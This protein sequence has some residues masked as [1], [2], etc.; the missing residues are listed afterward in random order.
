MQSWQ[1]SGSDDDKDLDLV[2]TGKLL[3]KLSHYPKASF[4]T[5]E[6]KKKAGSGYNK[7]SGS[8]SNSRQ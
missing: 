8:G 7:G 2:P 1:G 5:D 6:E 3:I 4:N